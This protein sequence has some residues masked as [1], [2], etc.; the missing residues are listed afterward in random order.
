MQRQAFET[1]VFGS[2]SRT[3]NQLFLIRFRFLFC[4]ASAN[5]APR[6][7][8]FFFKEVLAEIFGGLSGFG[9]TLGRKLLPK[10][11][12]TISVAADLRHG[13]GPA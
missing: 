8:R 7:F 9:S 2:I 4:R 5:T 13:G 6:Q 3:R 1:V 11:C 12:W 10:A